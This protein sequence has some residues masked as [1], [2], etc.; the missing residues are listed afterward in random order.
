MKF[1]LQYKPMSMVELRAEEAKLYSEIA[2]A[3]IANKG[4]FMLRK[5]LAI[6]KSYENNYR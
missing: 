6:V 5:R 4:V 2:K 3:K 1:K